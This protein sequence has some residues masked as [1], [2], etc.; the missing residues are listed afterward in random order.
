MS[1]QFV[2]Q[3]A[4][5]YRELA[6]DLVWLR[7]IQY[8]G[9][10]LMTDHKYEWLG[11]VFGILTTL[12]PRFI[13]AYHFGAMTLAWD[14]R[15]PQEDYRKGREMLLRRLSQGAASAG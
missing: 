11:H 10:H 1:G 7:A 14:A 2:R 3:A 5:E 9:Y 12:D 6:A 8:Y 13:G 15:K 4:F